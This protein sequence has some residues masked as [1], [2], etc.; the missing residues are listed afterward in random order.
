M[1]DRGGLPSSSRRAAS[2]NVARRGP[3]L[4]A[5]AAAPRRRPVR[6]G[7]WQVRGK[8][9][10]RAR[11]AT[12]CCSSV[13]RWR[14]TLSRSARA[15]ASAAAAFSRSARTRSVSC[16]R[17]RASTS[18]RLRSAATRSRAAAALS[19]ACRS[20]ESVPVDA[21]TA[22]RVSSASCSAACTTAS[23]W[24]YSVWLASTCA[25]ASSSSVRARAQRRVLGLDRR[26]GRLAPGAELVRLGGERLGPATEVLDLLPIELH[27]LLAATDLELPGVRL[28]ADA[29]RA[30]P[31]R[32]ARAG[33]P[34]GAIRAP[35][36]AR[37]RPPRARGRRPAAPP[38]PQSRG[39]APGGG[40]RTAPAPTGAV[41]RAAACSAAPARPAA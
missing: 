4:R 14:T 29:G 18:S 1:A 39:T 11:S 13:S 2:P 3:A 25:R 37:P 36:R 26:A 10:R 15:R 30:P 12:S 7:G 27:L 33:A 24:V 40:A 21:S 23:A 32:S 34:R 20:A 8:C 19:R 5:S 31:P 41:P 35:R 9:S 6:A 17:S 16:S 28:L 38:R 22:A